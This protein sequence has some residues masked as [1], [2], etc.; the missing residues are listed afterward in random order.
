MLQ[1]LNH[2]NIIVNKEVNDGI[3]EGPGEGSYKLDQE[4]NIRLTKEFTLWI[5]EK[6]PTLVTES[7]S[8]L[9]DVFKKVEKKVTK[10]KLSMTGE[11]LRGMLLELTEKE[12]EFALPTPEN[13]AKNMGLTRKRFKEYLSKLKGGNEDLI[14]KV[15]L[16]HFKKCVSYLMSTKRCSPEDAHESSLN[17]LLEIRKELMEDRIYY[18]NLGYYFTKRA[19][20]KLY[21]IQ[22]KRKEVVRPIDGIEI[23]DSKNLEED[24][25]DVQLQ[26]VVAEAVKKL[27]PHCQEILKL[28]YYEELSM[29][30]IAA[31]LNKN[32]DA[33]RQEAKRCRDKLR[34]LLGEDFYKQFSTYFK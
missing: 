26:K 27:N 30:E 25:F 2:K 11:M 20:N 1:Y 9:K 29:K 5:Q 6:Y 34:K 3:T 22:M 13:Q 24:M 12:C 8:I 33:I 23:E 18:G 4:A 19:Q 14:E 31:R 7:D 16:A 28:F 21:K 10:S 32:H 15:Y 17:A